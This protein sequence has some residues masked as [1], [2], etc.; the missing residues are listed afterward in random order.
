MGQDGL[1]GATALKAQGARVIA[2]DEASSV[3]WGM[4]GAVVHAGL[5]D[6]VLPLDRIAEALWPAA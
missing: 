6:H 4:P 3:V 2:Q 5:A 1:R